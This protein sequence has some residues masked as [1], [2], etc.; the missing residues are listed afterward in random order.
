MNIG[1]VTGGRWHN[2]PFLFLKK[3]GYNVV[4][5]DDNPNCYLKRKY[6]FIPYKLTKMVNFKNF[7]FWSPCNDKGSSLSDYFNKKNNSKI[8]FR[9]NKKN[10]ILFDKKKFS[11]LKEKIYFKEKRYLL[12]DRFGSGS[13]NIKF[14]EGKKFDKKKL[15]L[16]EYFKGF[17]LSIEVISNE[18]KHFLFAY[19][20]RIL[21]KFKSAKAIISFGKRK[22]FDKYLEKIIIEHLEKHKII[23]GVTHIELIIDKKSNY[24]IIDTNLRCP[25]AGLS[26]YFYNILTNQNLFEIDFKILFENKKINKKNIKIN[27][28]MILFDS[29]NTKNFN[30]KLKNYSKRLFYQNLDGEAHSLDKDKETDS[31]RKGLGVV[32]FNNQKELLLFCKK[33]LKKRDFN[34]LESFIKFVKVEF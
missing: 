15:Y 9:S 29:R 16:E 3:K 19:S 31:N 30:F 4:L 34:K 21:Q 23:N 13:K 20:L 7:T 32:K 27:H 33:L 11:T 22:K 6:S 26:D 12:K 5:F 10:L 14:W 2:K 18:G 25:G 1:L 24:Q 8:K 28:G 17:E